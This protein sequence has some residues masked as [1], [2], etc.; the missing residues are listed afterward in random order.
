MGAYTQAELLTV[1]AVIGVIAMMLVPSVVRTKNKAQR[2]ACVGYLKNIGLAFRIFAT[3]HQNLYPM[4]V[5]TNAGGTMEFNAKPFSAYRH[6]QVLSN[7]LSTPKTL[8]CRA[9]NR[10]FAKTWLALK[11]SN[12]SYFVGLDAT[13]TNATSLLAGDHAI[14]NSS[15]SIGGLLDLKPSRQAGWKNKPHSRS[16]N[17]ALG[18]GSVQQLSSKQ[19]DEFLNQTGNLKNRIALPE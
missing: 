4:R 19:L 12:L 16:G 1:V 7:E 8:V 13:E 3:D 10:H 14:T 11:N 15:R 17:V 2:I 18:D 6:V 5:S 9:D